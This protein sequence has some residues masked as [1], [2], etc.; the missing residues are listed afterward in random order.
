MRQ[1]EPDSPVA[2]FLNQRGDE[3]DR[4]DPVLL[5]LSGHIGKPRTHDGDEPNQDDE[6]SRQSPGVSAK[7]RD[8]S[9]KDAD[10]HGWKQAKKICR[11]ERRYSTSR[12]A[13][14]LMR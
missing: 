10:E 7:Q 3:H 12:A 14:A 11:L 6:S 2:V 8:P 1:G 5:E 4:C 13:S 9:R